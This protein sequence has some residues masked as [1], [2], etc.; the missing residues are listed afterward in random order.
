MTIRNV[1]NTSDLKCEG[2]CNNWLS[3]WER[4]KGKSATKCLISG[5]WRGSDVGAHVWEAGESKVYIIPMCS[6]HHAS[7]EA[8]PLNDTQRSNMVPAKA[9]ETCND[10]GLMDILDLM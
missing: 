4:N 3:H 7:E 1:P 5:C 9:L 2:G 10:K 8:M 6:Q